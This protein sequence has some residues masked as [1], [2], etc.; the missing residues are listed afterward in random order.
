MLIGSQNTKATVATVQIIGVSHK[1]PFA[2]PLDKFV[3]E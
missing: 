3:Q 2:P 1:N